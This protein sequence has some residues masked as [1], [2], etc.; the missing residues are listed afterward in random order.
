MRTVTFLL[1]ATVALTGCTNKDE[2]YKKKILPLYDSLAR[3]RDDIHDGIVSSGF[4]AD[5]DAATTLHEKA[6]HD[7][8]GEDEARTSFVNMQNALEGYI[9]LRSIASQA[10]PDKITL[11][12][13]GAAA[14]L[15]KAH[16]ALEKG[17]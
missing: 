5:C 16:A 13:K 8:S 4:S 6:Q 1:L 14:D 9:A 11:M 15:E 10:T 2:V 7:L 3:I 12:A 17:D